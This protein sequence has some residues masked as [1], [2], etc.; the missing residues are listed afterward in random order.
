VLLQRLEELGGQVRR[1]CDVVHVDQDDSGA[2]VT[3]AG[4]ER[5][6][7]AFVV[8]ADGV[9]STVREQ[10][11]I[12]LSGNPHGASYSLADVHLTGGVPAD[13]LVVHFS[14]AGHLVVCVS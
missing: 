1:P 11:K 12:G 2:T 6:R 10:A 3:F 14:P 13:E 8:G 7:A 4:G 5:V 9:H